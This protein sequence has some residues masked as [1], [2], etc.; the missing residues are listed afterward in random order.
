[1][2]RTPLPQTVIEGK[3]L[4]QSPGGTSGSVSSQLAKRLE[5]IGVDAALGDPLEQM[6]Q[7]RPWDV[8]ALN[9]RH[10]EPA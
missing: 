2:I 10:Q 6:P 5:G 4:N 7:K 3:R 8:F 1:L 9:F